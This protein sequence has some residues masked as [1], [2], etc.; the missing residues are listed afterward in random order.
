MPK[1]QHKQGVRKDYL[2]W[3]TLPFLLEK[4]ILMKDRKEGVPMSQRKN[5]HRRVVRNS[6]QKTNHTTPRLIHKRPED[7]EYGFDYTLL[8]TIVFLV[9]FGLIMLYSVSYNTGANKYAD[10]MYF[11]KNQFKFVIFGFLLLPLIL[12]IN[13]KIYGGWRSRVIY[14]AA[15]ILMIMVKFSP[16]GVSVNGA[17]RWLEFPVLGTFQPSEFMKVGI[18]TFTPTVIYNLKVV[19]LNNKS[20]FKVLLPGILA[21]IYTLIGTDNLST[22]IIIGGISLG[23]TLLLVEK[24]KE[25]IFIL[26]AFVGTVYLSLQ[27]FGEAL[28]NAMGGFRLSRLVVWLN[29]TEYSDTAGYQVLQGLYAIG[30]GGIFGKGLGNGTQKLSSIPEVQND[31]IFAAICEELGIFGLVIL[32]FLFGVLLYRL[33]IIAQNAPTLHS[34]LIVVG[35][36]LHIALQVVVNLGVVTGLLPNTGVTLPFISYGGT[37]MLVLLC[38]MWIALGISR[39]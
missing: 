21:A 7:R 8:I 22:A 2:F 15:F 6:Q 5:I 34:S 25:T 27:L 24:F 36:F 11:L 1:K 3:N 39:Q 20:A 19:Q 12:T 29:P 33:F 9:T 17:E 13:H 10:G 31:M 28:F 38:E 32:L 30:A 14:F 35:I 23:I 37:A 18:I 16:F 26:L 4:V